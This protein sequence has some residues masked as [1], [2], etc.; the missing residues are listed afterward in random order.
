[1]HAH[2]FT[3][4]CIKCTYTEMHNE[5]MNIVG[6]HKHALVSLPEPQGRPNGVTVPY[7]QTRNISMNGPSRIN[8]TEQNI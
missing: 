5:S 2:M 3:H 6:A 4:P 1:M 8:I 7:F